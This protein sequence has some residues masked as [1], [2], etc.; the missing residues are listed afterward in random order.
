L[1]ISTNC[2]RRCHRLAD[3]LLGILIR[4]GGVDDVN[5]L[6]QQEIQDLCRVLLLAFEISDLR[7]PEAQR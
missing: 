1:L 4:R 2:F 7:R 3:Q 6:I 5:A